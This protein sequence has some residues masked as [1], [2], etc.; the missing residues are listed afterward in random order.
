MQNDQGTKNYDELVSI[1]MVSYNKKDTIEESIKSVRAQTY[2]NWELLIEDDQSKDGTIDILMDFLRADKRLRIYQTTKRRGAGKN[3]S[4]IL[5]EANGRWV[6]FLEC[7]DTWEPN[8][9]ERQVAYMKNNDYL[10]S[11]TACKKVIGGKTV[12]VSGPEIVSYNMMRKFCWLEHSTAM[13]DIKETG[14][15]RIRYSKD[16]NYYALWLQVSKIA[17]CHLLNE[18]LATVGKNK[19]RKFTWLKKKFRWRYEVYRIVEKKN[20]I[21]SAYMTLRNLWYTALYRY[22]NLKQA[23]T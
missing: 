8:K 2:L 1:I 13:Y 22:K 7:G 18:N 12:E 19:K 9:L 23:N 3:R 10:F 4:S 17:D 5:R 20:Q 14:I 6:A 16:N 11:Y 21:V 15:S